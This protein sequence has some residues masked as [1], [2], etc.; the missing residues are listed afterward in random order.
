MLSLSREMF[1]SPPLSIAD[2]P[3]HPKA[4]AK[5]YPLMRCWRRHAYILPSFFISV[6]IW[7][8]FVTW[9]DWKL[10][11][12]EDFCGFYDALARSIIHGHLD[13]PRTAIG[14]EAFTF[15][16]KTY[17]YFGI[18]PA[19]L[20]IPLILIFPRMDGLWSRLLILIAASISLMCAYRIM[21][22]VSLGTAANTRFQRLLHSL[23]ILSAGV[24]STTVFLV[25][26]SYTYH[27]AL[28]WSGAFAL[29]FTCTILRYFSRPRG[30]LLALAGAFAFMSFHCR[31]TVGLGALLAVTALAAILIWRA[32]TQPKAAQSFLGLGPVAAPAR[33]ALIATIIV[34]ITLGTYFGVNYAKFRT[35]DAV[36][37]RYYDFYAE[38]PKRLKA[39]EGK[40]IHLK[41]IPTGLATYFGV[42]GVRLKNKFPWFYMEEEATFIGSPANDVIESFST[43]PVSMPALMLLGVIGSAALISSSDEKLHRARLPALSLFLGGAIVLATV[44]IT[45]RYLHDFYPALIICAAAG[46]ARVAAGGHIKAITASTAA[47][48]TLSIVLNCSFSLINQRENLGAPPAK[49]AEY[50]HLQESI[51]RILHRG[52]PPPD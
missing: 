47:L 38:F 50:E 2:L 7:T 51:N 28:M 9:G 18:G 25:G 22:M 49:V 20:R 5:E 52:P 14:V 6:L 31:P 17:G 35:F 33:H 42:H 40:Q 36:P 24:G 27:E 1:A 41:N 39:T 12:P 30:S 23:F 46:A 48:A 3:K 19:L 29:L 32:I 11:E 16:G 4:V 10:F 26:R 43:V 45:E 37:L 44:G 34:A 13:V 15:E 21:R 8:W